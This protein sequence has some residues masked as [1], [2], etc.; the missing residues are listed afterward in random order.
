MMVSA[1]ELDQFAALGLC[2]A[3]PYMGDHRHCEQCDTETVDGNT[4]YFNSETGQEFI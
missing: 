3:N 1:A 2:G 4:R